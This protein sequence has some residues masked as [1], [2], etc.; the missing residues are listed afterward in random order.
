MVKVI[1]KIMSNNRTRIL[2]LFKILY[3][4]TDE[5]NK[6]KEKDITALLKQQGLKCDRRSFYDDRDAL[7]AAGVDIKYKGGYYIA[8]RN[9]ELSEIKFLVDYIASSETLTVQ[10][11]ENLKDKL[12]SLLSVSQRKIVNE[13]FYTNPNIKNTENNNLMF[14]INDLVQAIYNQKQVKFR[15]NN[16]N[17]NKQYLFSPY[18]LVSS[19]QRYYVI[20]YNHNK[21]A[22]KIYHFK[23]E[24]INEL[25]ATN[26]QAAPINEISDDDYFDIAEYMIKTYNMYSGEQTKVKLQ[27]KG[28]I[29]DE[30]K[31][32]FE[33]VKVKD[34]PKNMKDKFIVAE[35]EVSISDGFISFVLSMRDNIQVLEPDWVVDKVKNQ[36][37]AIL[38]M[39]N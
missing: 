30:I 22:K 27:F 14:V 33:N 13:Q 4:Q 15:Y 8:T 34:L 10:Q 12:L 35:V 18:A 16:H 5:N 7:I 29:F 26:N 17:A 39:Y 2:S 36:A 25:K 11:S 6:L 23:V 9:F 3:E 21:Y 24:K 32:H 37:K 28:I 1:G 31:K 20:G 38:D 19:N